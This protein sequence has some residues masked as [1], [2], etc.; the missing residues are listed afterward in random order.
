M[1]IPYDKGLLGHSDADVATHALI[2]AL[3]GA[4]GLSYIGSQFPDSETRYKGISSLELLKNTCW[5]LSNAG[6]MP[7]NA[8]ITIAAQAPKLAPFT[9]LM[10]GR[11]AACLQ[12]PESR[13]SVKATTT[14]GLGFE[15]EGLGIS[16][17]A[18]VTVHFIS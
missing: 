15:G 8:D 17:R 10:R 1:G 9:Q 2:D 3:I 5:L 6:F 16:A 11:L 4:A 18:A 13:V 7:Y 12:I 14:E